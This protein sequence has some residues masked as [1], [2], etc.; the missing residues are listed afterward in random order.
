M[1]VAAVAALGVRAGATGTS[2]EPARVPRTRKLGATDLEISDIPFG[3][4]TTGDPKVV[5]GLA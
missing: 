5:L 1:A 3:T 2:A 4:G